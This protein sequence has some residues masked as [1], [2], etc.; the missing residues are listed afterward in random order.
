MDDL[1]TVDSKKVIAQNPD[2][3]VLLEFRPGETLSF[4]GQAKV[5]STAGEFSIMN[6]TLL[7]SKDSFY[8]CSPQYHPGSLLTITASSSSSATENRKSLQTRPKSHTP[9]TLCIQPVLN[10]SHPNA[11]RA[12][13][14]KEDAKQQREKGAKIIE[15]VYG[16]HIVYAGTEDSPYSLL[17]LPGQWLIASGTLLD[18]CRK[19]M[20]VRV[21]VA[22]NR[23]VG[24]STC[25]RA[26]V[27]KLLDGPKKEVVLLDTD[28]G[29]CEFTPPGLVTLAI[30]STPLLSPPHSRLYPSSRIRYKHLQS[31]YVGATESTSN[32]KGYLNAVKFAIEKYNAVYGDLPLV[33]NTQGWLK[34]FGLSLFQSIVLQAN[35]TSIFHLTDKP[36]QLEL[37]PSY[38]RILTTLPQRP[39]VVK[40]KITASDLRRLALLRY[41]AGPS[42]DFLTAGRILAKKPPYRVCW[43]SV[44]ISILPET[45][46]PSSLLKSLN[47]SI[48]GLCT[49]PPDRLPPKP[50]RKTYA[51]AVLADSKSSSSL[52]HSTVHPQNPA[53]Q[54]LHT[55]RVEGCLCQGLGLIR[56][57]D[58]EKRQLLILSPV[59]FKDLRR[60]N[61]VI[62]GEIPVLSAMM[63]GGGVKRKAEEAMYTT[64]KSIQG[65][66]PMKSR[67]NI[68]RKWGGGGP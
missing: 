23:N 54:L 1:S 55:S 42:A 12:S 58:M 34:G 15:L 13:K 9:P 19:G 60:V 22:G 43:S 59:P 49:L 32:P 38:Q 63:T 33:I 47:A 21:I 14:L 65:F 16:F 5:R 68:G 26:V 36:F 62:R 10:R 57:I 24:K 28:V 29:Q 48:V 3:S 11:R 20:A 52:L 39:P 61:V 66:G 50:T 25:C 46:G 44:W 18:Q 30:L 4:Y 35:P 53:I 31:Y 17:T 37:E 6:Y 51:E 8:V 56:G 7:P 41:F 64:W 67:K 45:L 40:S 2:G 27:N